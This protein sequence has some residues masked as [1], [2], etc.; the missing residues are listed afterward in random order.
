MNENLKCSTLIFDFD[1]TLADSF[2]AAVNIFNTLAPK[3]NLQKINPEKILHLRNLTSAELI[4]YLNIPIY[5]LPKLMYQAKKEMRSQ[6]HNLPP[7]FASAIFEELQ[8][9][10]VMLGILSSNSKEN[11]ESWLAQNNMHH[12]FKF[13]HTNSNY[14]G[15][16]PI[17]SKIL[18]KYKI[19]RQSVFYIGDE[20]RDIEAAKK[21]QIKSIAVT[22]GFNSKQAL[23]AC[24]PDYIINKPEELLSLL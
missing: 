20:T 5:K 22:W 19:K 3:Y 15:K 6:L 7:L 2:T 1:G 13:I 11:I 14:L 10:G 21:N 9:K 17:L 4:R 23:S 24:L 16:S 12:F 18:E 8:K